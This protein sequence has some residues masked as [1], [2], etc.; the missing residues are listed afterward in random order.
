MG[1]HRDPQLQLSENEFILKLFIYLCRHCHFYE[2]WFL[3]TE[4]YVVFKNQ[5]LLK[6]CK[7]ST[8]LFVPIS[9]PA[10]MTLTIDTSLPSKI[11]RQYLLTVQVSRYCSLDLQNRT[12]QCQS[13]LR[14]HIVTAETSG[15][16]NK[17]PHLFFTTSS[18]IA[19]NS[20]HC[21]SETLW[22]PVPEPAN[23]CSSRWSNELIWNC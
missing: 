13:P 1:R 15:C 12:V 17:T 8:T 20:C 19:C 14:W 10:S 11:K 16:H 9:L 6:N 22:L 2:Q 5:L 18:R 21:P 7:H 4:K 23:I 3:N